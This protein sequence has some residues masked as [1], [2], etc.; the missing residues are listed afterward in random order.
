MALFAPLIAPF[1]QAD[2][3]RRRLGRPAAQD[4]LGLDNL[5]R[6]LLSRLIYGARLTIGLSLVI[7]LLSF[8]IGITRASA[9]R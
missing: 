7:T 4:W 1:D 9:P 5:G 8:A 2:V 6:D 3:G